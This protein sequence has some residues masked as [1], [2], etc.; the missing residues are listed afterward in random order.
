MVGRP[1]KQTVDY[2]PH[3]T[4]SNSGKT[5]SILQSR[6]GNNGYAVWFKILERLGRSEGHYLDLNDE[7]DWEFFVS[8]MGISG[9]E[10][11]EI[12]NLLARLKAIDLE[13]WSKKVIWSDNFVKRLEL[14]YEKRKGL[15]PRKPEFPLRKVDF[16]DVSGSENTQREGKGRE[17]K[18]SKLKESKKNSS[19]ILDN[20]LNI[21]KETI[22]RVR[23]TRSR[24]SEENL[25]QANYHLQSI[26]SYMPNFKKPSKQELKEWAISMRLMIE[27]DNRVLDEIKEI[28]DWISAG[29]CED[30]IFWQPNILSTPKLRKQFNQIQGKMNNWKRKEKI[31]AS[32]LGE[33]GL[34]NY[35]AGL[36]WMEQQKKE[37]GINE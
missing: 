24:F 13:L 26:I 1:K 27:K 35:E 28:I 21:R 31:R 30:A 32:P 16:G 37:D 20:K 7:I 19:L 5:I 3:D 9:S 33:L 12:L 25:E 8:E 34:R 18:E 15:I 14:V 22:T 2:F 10:T 36:R 6:F 4:N 17:L 23:S 11:I 29:N